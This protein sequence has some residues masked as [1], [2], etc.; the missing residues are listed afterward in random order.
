MRS[1]NALLMG[2]L[3]ILSESYLSIRAEE[4][5]LQLITA[6]EKGPGND[7]CS[8]E[9]RMDGLIFSR[10]RSRRNGKARRSFLP[11]F[12]SVGFLVGS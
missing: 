5:P 4:E 6:H 1:P 10:G 8:P 3:F 9:E 7:R 11:L 2:P 12:M